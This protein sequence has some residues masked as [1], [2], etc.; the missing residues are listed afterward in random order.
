LAA[1]LAPAGAPP[2]RLL[3]I[4]H[5]RP[6]DLDAVAVGERPVLA[7]HLAEDP[8]LA[9]HPGQQAG[10]FESFLHRG[11]LRHSHPDALL[12]PGQRVDD[13]NLQR[14]HIARRRGA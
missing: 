8:D 4:E 9:A 11:A 13:F 14:G 12:A 10:F 2:A 7:H 5:Q 1:V 6:V 3:G